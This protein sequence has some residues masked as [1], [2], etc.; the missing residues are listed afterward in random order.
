MVTVAYA[1]EAQRAFEENARFSPHIRAL[2]HIDFSAQS[3][4]R[5]ESRDNVRTVPELLRDIFKLGWT[6]DWISVPTL[7]QGELTGVSILL[8]HA[9]LGEKTL[10]LGAELYPSTVGNSLAEKEGTLVDDLREVSKESPSLRV[11]L[12]RINIAL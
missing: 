5:I 7:G 4:F 1:Q 3:V 10:G 11:H 8:S 2:A 9:T 6:V 12:S